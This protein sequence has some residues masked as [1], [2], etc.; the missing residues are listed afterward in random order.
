[1]VTPEERDDFKDPDIDGRMILKWIL[2]KQGVLNDLAGLRIE[3]RCGAA[4]NM[5]M[6]SKFHIRNICLAEELSVFQ[7]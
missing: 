1:V 2:K 6:N 4:V 7:D 3:T 5:V